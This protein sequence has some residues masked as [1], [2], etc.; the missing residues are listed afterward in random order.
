MNSKGLKGTHKIGGQKEVVE[1]RLG[2]G[3]KEIAKDKSI[4]LYKIMTVLTQ[5]LGL[6]QLMDED[7]ETIVLSTD[8]LSAIMATAS[9]NHACSNP[10]C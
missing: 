6:L 1:D 3:G 8:Q 7:I 10:L 2:A 4:F 5:N 9:L